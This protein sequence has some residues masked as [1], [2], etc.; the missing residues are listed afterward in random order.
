MAD[1]EPK[2]DVETCVVKVEGAG[3]FEENVAQMKKTFHDQGWTFIETVFPMNDKPTMFF[4]RPR[5][6]L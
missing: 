3:T 4:R 2:D 1:Q 6:S 5:R